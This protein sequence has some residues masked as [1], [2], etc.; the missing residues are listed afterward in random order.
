MSQ[1]ELLAPYILQNGTPE[2]RVDLIDT[3]V[4]SCLGH[5]F[6]SQLEKIYASVSIPKNV[7]GQENNITNYKAA[8]GTYVTITHDI[9]ES[10]RIYDWQ[11]LSI[12]TMS[13]FTTKTST[14]SN[15][16]IDVQFNIQLESCLKDISTNVIMYIKSKYETDGYAKTLID[17]RQISRF[18][19]TIALRASYLYTARGISLPDKQQTFSKDLLPPDLGNL[20]SNVFV[21]DMF[22]LFD[23]IRLYDQSEFTEWK[24]PI[25]L[26]DENT[27]QQLHRLL[28]FTSKH[29]N[30]SNSPCWKC[31]IFPLWISLIRRDRSTVYI[32]YH[33]ESINGY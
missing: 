16:N 17:I 23:H 14:T 5:G 7:V 4:K 24:G 29:Y 25:A 26:I 2:H 11:Q 22:S 30:R 12:R 3:W 20:I 18:I 15:A 1:Y 28:L 6:L 8:I 33:R 27:L 31:R 9:S 21:V 13:A 32:E 19:R 10:R